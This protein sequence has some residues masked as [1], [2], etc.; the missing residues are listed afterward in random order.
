MMAL[1]MSGSAWRT[2]PSVASNQAQRKTQ[3]GTNYAGP[4]ENE[5]LQFNLWDAI[6][7][8]ADG[9]SYDFYFGMH[10]AVNMESTQLT[11]KSCSR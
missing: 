9:I 2:D 11:R 6:D 8:R 5:W 1:N 3:S 7:Y 4:D 10:A